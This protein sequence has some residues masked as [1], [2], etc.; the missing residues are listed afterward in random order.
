M[1]DVEPGY[2]PDAVRSAQVPELGR[3]RLV[4]LHRVLLAGGGGP[5]D[6]ALVVP[7]GV[8]EAVGPRL[9]QQRRQ[10]RPVGGQGGQL[11]QAVVPEEVLGFGGP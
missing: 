8:D 11:R 1:E 7:D 3:S 9:R 6:L 2:G 4:P 5:E 10:G